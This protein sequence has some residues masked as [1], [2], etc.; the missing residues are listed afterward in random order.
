MKVSIGK[1]LDNQKVQLNLDAFIST[2]GAVAANSG[3]GK[4]YL[5]QSC[6][7][8]PHPLDERTCLSL[9]IDQRPWKLFSVDRLTAV[10]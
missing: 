5:L 10:P 7:N 2:R 9:N 3:G 4:S 6:R 8:P 1:T